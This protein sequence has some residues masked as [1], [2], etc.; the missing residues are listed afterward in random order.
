M[1][2]K[3]RADE[4]GKYHKTLREQIRENRA[5]AAVYIVLRALVV[6]VMVA[7]FFNGNFENVFLCV[8]TLVLFFIPSFIERTVKIDVPDTLEVIILLFIFAAE[9]L[10]EIRAYYIQYP[11]WD[12]M[13]HTL[14]GFLCAAI[15][16]SL[17]DILNRSDRFT[18]SLSP[19]YLAVVAFCFSMT[20]GVLWEF[21]EW[22]MDSFFH[23]DMQKDTVV[24]AIGTV[25]LDPTGGNVPQHIKGITDVI[26]VTADG[27]QRSLGLGGYLDIGLNDTMKDLFVNFIGALVFSVIGYFYVKSR[28]KGRFARRFIPRLVKESGEKKTEE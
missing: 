21:F 8:L 16:F 22:A 6:L 19:V 24:H 7:Q 10:G 3:K 2:R 5:L 20:V 25:M 18:F 4:A 9:I 17:V 15:G 27:T 28:G 14:N 23:L 12:T 26:V 11:Y 13:L 1:R